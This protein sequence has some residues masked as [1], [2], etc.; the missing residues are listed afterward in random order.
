VRKRIGDM[1]KIGLIQGYSAKVNFSLMENP[2]KAYITVKASGKH[3]QSVVRQLVKH[4]RAIAVYKLAGETDIMAVTA[5]LKP[6]MSLAL[7][8]TSGLRRFLF[9]H[10]WE[11]GLTVFGLFSIGPFDGGLCDCVFSIVLLNASR[12]R[13]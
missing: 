9:S 8:R 1:E 3:R 10:V 2:V 6:I 12:C 7:H 11:G 13:S 4:P 5:V